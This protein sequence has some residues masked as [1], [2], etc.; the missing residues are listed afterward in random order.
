[1]QIVFSLFE[2]IKLIGKGSFGNVFQARRK[3]DNLLCVLKVVS[4]LSLS[5]EEKEVALNE[6]TALH[7]RNHC[8]EVPTCESTGSPQ[9]CKIL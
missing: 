3:A 7:T 6:V 1:M 9:Y 5:R 4:L 2:V 8:F